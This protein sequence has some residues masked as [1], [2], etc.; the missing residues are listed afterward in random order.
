[1]TRPASAGVSVI[2]L[3]LST[4]ELGFLSLWEISEEYPSF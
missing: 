4:V 2:N 1:M 3:A